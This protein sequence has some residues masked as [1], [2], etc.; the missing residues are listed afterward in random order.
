MTRRQ[1][2]AIIV[3]IVTAFAEAGY[4]CWEP[5]IQNT[6]YT[7]QELVGVPLGFRFIP[8]KQ[9][10]FSFDLRDEITSMRADCL[11]D[12]RLH[13]QWQGPGLVVTETGW[14]FRERWPRTVERYAEI[15]RFIITA[16][17]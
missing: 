14:A 13:S 10:L 4:R 9:R 12:I 8:Y 2:D 7:L 16:G 17:R 6:V 11:I 15:V 3:D 1:R 5:D